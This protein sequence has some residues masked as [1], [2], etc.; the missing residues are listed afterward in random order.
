MLDRA[1]LRDLVAAE[2]PDAVVHLA[3]QSHVPTAWKNPELT[4]QVNVLGSLHL[5]EAIAEGAPDASVLSVGSAEIYGAAAPE[6]MP[7]T[8]D[9]PLRPQ[10]PYAVSKA[11]QDLLAA[12]WAVSPGLAIVRA[13]PFNHTGPGQSDAFVC[14][15]FARLAAEIALGKHEPEV[16]VG[17]LEVRR[18]FLD[19]RNVCRAYIA[20]LSNGEAGE[21][22]NIASSEACL[23]RDILDTILGFT[24]KEVEIG[25]DPDKFRPADTPVFCGSADRLHTATGWKPEIAF[26]QTLKDLYEDWLEKLK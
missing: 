7:L 26:E 23:I 3:A 19:V 13:R 9:A 14:S 16:A 5:F 18:D 24:E 22:Y 6:E 2:R 8:E 12:Q 4:F 11:A 21:V 17:N 20:L 10:N 15:S 25:T 1:G